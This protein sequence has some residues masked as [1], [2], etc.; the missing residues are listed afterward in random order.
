MHFFLNIN[1]YRVS[2]LFLFYKYMY[3]MNEDVFRYYQFVLF[4]LTVN[5]YFKKSIYYGILKLNM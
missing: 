2:K 3:D 1:M 5:F 4:E